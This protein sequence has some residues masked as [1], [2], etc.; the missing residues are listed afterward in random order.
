MSWLYRRN[1]GCIE[2]LC[3]LMIWFHTIL[4]WKDMSLSVFLFAKISY[5]LSSHFTSFHTICPSYVSLNYCFEP[6]L[7][8]IDTVSSFLLQMI[9]WSSNI[10]DRFRDFWGSIKI[11]ESFSE[12]FRNFFGTFLELSQIFCGTFWMFSGTFSELLRNFFGTFRNFFGTL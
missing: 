11:S 1:M 6:V 8:L 5:I 2:F 10:L 9:Q 12:L 3:Q 7:V 4:T